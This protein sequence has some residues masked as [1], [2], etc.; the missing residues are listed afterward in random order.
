AIFTTTLDD[1]VALFAAPKARRGAASA[2]KE[3]GADPHSGKPVVVKSGRYGPYVTDGEVNATLPRGESPEE[4]TLERAAGLL[5]DK[6]A[7][8]PATPRAGGRARGGSRSQGATSRTSGGSKGAGSRGG[9]GK[10]KGAGS[11]T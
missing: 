8:G 6:R 9:A 11:A 4:I 1:A 10:S 2:L 3:L 5:A 7:K